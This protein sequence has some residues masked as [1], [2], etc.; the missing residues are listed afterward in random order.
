M[1]DFLYNTLIQ[2]LLI[3]LKQV[4]KGELH[5][6]ATE[7]E[8][9][10]EGEDRRRFLRGAVGATVSTA[11]VLSMPLS[12]L[13]AAEGKE[14]EE[15]VLI[16]IAFSKIRL[17]EDMHP[18]RVMEIILKNQ[19]YNNALVAVLKKAFAIENK[20]KLNKKGL[21]PA[22]LIDVPV[23]RNVQIQFEAQGCSGGEIAGA[24]AIDIG[25]AFVTG[26]VDG[27]LGT[28]S[29][30]GLS[31]ALKYATNGKDCGLV[32][33]AAKNIAGVGKTRHVHLNMPVHIARAAGLIKARE[34]QEI[35][36][37]K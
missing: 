20:D 9:T 7:S 32:A 28:A 27:L 5:T 30:T 6:A 10:R 33:Q 11:T 2:S 37:S 12:A 1:L 14:D 13:A 23:T 21:L 26:G 35:A 16:P 8:L 29:N 17:E 25:S 24:T 19:N 22:G 34:T 31:S 3:S 15:M 36:S 18:S 4:N